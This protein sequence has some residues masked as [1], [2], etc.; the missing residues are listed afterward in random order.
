MYDE[1]VILSEDGDP[2]R[3][4]SDNYILDETEVEADS[5]GTP[6]LVRTVRIPLGRLARRR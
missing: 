4:E 2:I 6:R 5:I 1:N 3:D